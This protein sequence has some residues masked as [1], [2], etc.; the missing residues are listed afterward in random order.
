MAERNYGRRNAANRE[1]L[2]IKGIKDI[3]NVIC[4]G[5][6]K[7]NCVGFDDPDKIGTSND[8]ETKIKVRGDRYQ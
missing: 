7:I 2:T 4:Y 6:C 8:D 5:E 1:G 3:K